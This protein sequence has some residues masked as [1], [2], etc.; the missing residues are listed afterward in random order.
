MAVP[1][2]SAIEHADG[3][4][5]ATIRRVLTQVRSRRSGGAA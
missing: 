2:F 1:L 4:I 5:G 3:E